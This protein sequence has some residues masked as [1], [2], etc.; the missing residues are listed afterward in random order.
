[1]TTACAQAAPRAIPDFFVADC[2]KAVVPTRLVGG[3]E[4]RNATGLDAIIFFTHR[5]SEP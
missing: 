3:M 5:D 2:P 4:P 1:M